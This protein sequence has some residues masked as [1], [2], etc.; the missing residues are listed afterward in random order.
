MQISECITQGAALLKAHGIT[1]P[2]LESKIIMCMVL[3]FS[4][5][6]MLLHQGE[7]LSRPDK[8]T[9]Q[10]LLMRRAKGE[11]LAY[12]TQHKE[13]YGLKFFVNNYVLIPRPDTE[14]M[15]ER[16][17]ENHEKSDSLEILELGVGSG[18]V[19]ISLLKHLP[20][21]RALGID[22]SKEALEI[23][24]KNA[25]NL[26]VANRITFRQSNWYQ[27]VTGKFDLVISNPPYVDNKSKFISQIDFE[28]EIALFAQQNGLANYY[29]IAAGVKEFLK[30]DGSCYVEIGIES[31][32]NVVE[33][34]SKYS[35]K[36]ASIY[37]DLGQIERCLR[38][39]V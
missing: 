8:D 31:K 37:K 14:I 35:V 23:A 16:V 27:N 17:L 18:C 20:Y 24:Q 2:R 33:I 21:A 39:V 29:E 30:K 22:L 3:G 5:E 25:E 15:V 28:P 12:I 1:N 7:Q 4:L 38:F 13:F 19:I 9:F 10:N 11:P 36:L 34:F 32:A 6:E 26:G